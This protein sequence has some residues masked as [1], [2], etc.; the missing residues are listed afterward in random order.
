MCDLILFCKENWAEHN[1]LLILQAKEIKFSEVRHW[2]MFLSQLV[3]KDL[4][5]ILLHSIC[6]TSPSYQAL[7]LH[8]P[9]LMYKEVDCKEIYLNLT[10]DYIYFLP[11][12]RG[13]YKRFE[14]WELGLAYPGHSRKASWRWGCLNWVLTERLKLDKWKE[15][16]VS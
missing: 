2:V 9:I 1:S 14:S 13:K 16:N 10:L 12:D 4:N 6:S 3:S 15:W 8:Q 7:S 5:S 11:W